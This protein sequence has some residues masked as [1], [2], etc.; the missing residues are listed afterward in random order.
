MMRC[1]DCKFQALKLGKRYCHYEMRYLSD[2]ERGCIH[3]VYFYDKL[4]GQ[5]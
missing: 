3:G 4:E 2:G 1:E 5:R